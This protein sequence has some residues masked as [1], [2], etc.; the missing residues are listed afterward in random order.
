MSFK[1]L[2]K[3]FKVDHPWLWVMLGLALL[4]AF[5]W[6]MGAGRALTPTPPTLE[7]SAPIVNAQTSQ[8]VTADVLID[9]VIVSR[10]VTHLE[11]T[12]PLHTWQTEIK[13]R[14]DGYADWAIAVQGQE[15]RHLEG[16]IRLIPK[17]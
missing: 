4:V 6:G 16:P 7:I 13:V 15:S 5:I 9:G 3:S 12:L 11:I 14:A 1:V 17:P 10:R 2:G 8:P